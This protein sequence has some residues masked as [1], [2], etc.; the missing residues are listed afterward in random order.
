MNS[1]FIPYD[2]ALAMKVL[3][4]FN[5]PCLGKYLVTDPRDGNDIVLEIWNDENTYYEPVSMINAPLYQQA[6]KFFRE[7]YGFVFYIHT[8]NHFGEL[9]FHPVIYMKD[10]KEPIADTLLDEWDTYEDAEL[11]CLKKLIEIVKQKYIKNE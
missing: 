9:D 1:E 2:E 4:N 10:S 11:A 3:L 5:E 7:N 8:C 6:F